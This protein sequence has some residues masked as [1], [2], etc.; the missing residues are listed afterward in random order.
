MPSKD[1][2]P[3][4]DSRTGATATPLHETL[5]RLS[6][7]AGIRGNAQ[8]ASVF[9]R[10]AALVRT[11]GI[12]S[13]RELEPLL[14]DP[15]QEGD[16]EVLR[17]LR[18]MHQ[19][20]AW[21][22]VESAMADLPSDLRRIVESGALTIDQLA[23]LHRALGVTTAVD[24]AAEVRRQGIRRVPGLDEAA[25]LRVARALPT[26]RAA[27]TPVPLGRAAALAEP[28]L[29]RLRGTRGVLWAEAAG[30][31]RRGQA[32]V[33]D[34]ELVAPTLDPAPALDAAL[35]EV[36]AAQLLHR[37]GR[38]LYVRA[39]QVQIGVRCPEP[40]IGGSVL[41]HLTGTAAHVR[42]LAE[43]A[44]DRG[45]ALT[46]EGLARR[47]E[48]D[49]I[50][51]SE[52][53][54]YAALDLPWIP[55][56]I[57]DGGEEIDVAARGALPTL[58]VGRDVRGDLHM[59]TRWSDGR[60]ST[61][62]M[63]AASAAAG[64]EYIA[65]TDHSQQ[66]AASR[67]LHADQVARQAEEITALRDRFPRLTI[68][69][70]CEVDILADGALDFDDRTLERFDIVL[71]SLHE[72]WGQEPDELLRRYL[73]AVRHPLVAVITHPTNRMIPYRH[74]YELDYDRLFE[75]AVET[76]TAI[77]ID[78]APQH[79]DMDGTLA[80]RAVAAGVTVIVSSDSHRADMLERQMGFGV[81]T[82]RRGWVEARHVLNTRPIADVR[83]FIAAKRRG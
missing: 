69:H 13:D 25:E 53:A 34:V 21:I 56:E 6:A 79:L 45:F 65:I 72:Q 70:G 5:E 12:A 9:A 23:A 24:L 62:A 55:V 15:P 40:D 48:D 38:R 67:T 61:E 83:A 31:L 20:G 63:V 68:L 19:A 54:I 32:V 8:A 35:D 59:H 10:A 37:S 1:N 76:G 51:D 27:L 22:L 58:L 16:V 47:R 73:R 74:G 3:D 36:G 26:L 2:R 11:H 49:R 52:E 14:Q 57:R 81:R 29:E 39:D 17:Q 44:V 60:H 82:A 64:Y 43:R 41:L 33:G 75:A 80:R 66:A 46:P 4:H 28:I 71:A 78:G 77:E 42:K 18:H 7:I 50:G 30:S